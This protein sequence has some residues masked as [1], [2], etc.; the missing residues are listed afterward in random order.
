MIGN[1]YVASSNFEH[2]TFDINL[3]R[4]YTSILVLDDG[5]APLHPHPI[6]ALK[7]RS[8]KLIWMLP[9][10]LQPHPELLELFVRSEAAIRTA[11]ADPV[12]LD[13]NPAE[14]LQHPVVG[15]VFL[16]NSPSARTMPVWL[17]F[18]PIFFVIS[19]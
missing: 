8:N 18:L 5:L 6:G 14:E 19:A 2:V 4:G 7:Y 12:A 9:Q 3:C 1:T 15:E 10:P 16:Y 13:I 17:S 11:Q